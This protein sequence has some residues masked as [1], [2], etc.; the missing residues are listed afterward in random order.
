MPTFTYDPTTT[1][2]RVR[3]LAQD[4]DA[5]EPI[6]DDSEI[7]AFLDMNEGDIRFAAAMALEVLAANEVYVQKRIKILDLWTDGPREADQLLRI[8]E[9]YRKQAIDNV[10]ADETFDWAEHVYNAWTAH[11][12]VVNDLLRLY[13]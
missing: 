2:G 13:A 7:E 10:S 5:S 12:R 6:F 11:E 9:S 4:F 1:E 3:L 8:A